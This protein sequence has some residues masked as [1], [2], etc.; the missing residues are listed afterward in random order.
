MKSDSVYMGV[1][2]SKEKL[3]IFN[4][5]TKTL[6]SEPNSPEGF[7]KIREAARKAKAVVCCEPTGSL[8]LNMV[9]FYKSTIFQLF[10]VMA[11]V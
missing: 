6:T 2:V 7:R 11:F 9:M 3:D 10:I 4:P 8:E 1:D 5:H